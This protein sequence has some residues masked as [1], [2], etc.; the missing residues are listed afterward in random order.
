MTK[1]IGAVLILISVIISG[2]YIFDCVKA[3]YEWNNQY[4][5][6]W[7]LSDKASSIQQ[8]SAYLDQFVS[9]LQASGLQGTQD[10]IFFPTPDNSFNQNFVALQSLQSRLHDVQ[11]MDPNSFQY[12]TA[13]EQIT[14]QEQ[15]GGSAM[16]QNFSD[17]WYKVHHYF[18]WNGW[19]VLGIVVGIVLMFVVGVCM[20]IAGLDD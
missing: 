11:T 6:Y 9:A 10:S 20:L 3:N 13:I 15:D 14:A 19:A 7:T 5:S 2:F 17:D 18:L 12:N 1:T 8:K 16:I 4:L